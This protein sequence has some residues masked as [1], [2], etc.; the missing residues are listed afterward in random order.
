MTK[1]LTFQ[2]RIKY[3]D[4]H[5]HFLQSLVT[6]EIITFKACDTNEQVIDIL[7]KSFS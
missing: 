1:N 3:I 4:I 2:N 5:Y 7:T 6:N